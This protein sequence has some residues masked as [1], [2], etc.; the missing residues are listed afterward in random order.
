MIYKQI[1]IDIKL[2]NIY[3]IKIKQNKTKNVYFLC[4]K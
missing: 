3:L 1:N 2:K 4:I